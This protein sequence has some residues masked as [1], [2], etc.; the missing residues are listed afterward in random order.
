MAQLGE[1]NPLEPLSGSMGQFKPIGDGEETTYDITD[2]ADS[3]PGVWL[4][5]STLLDGH[6]EG[7]SVGNICMCGRERLERLL[8]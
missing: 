2:A 6:P 4:P 3:V 1:S 8:N 5:L 7:C